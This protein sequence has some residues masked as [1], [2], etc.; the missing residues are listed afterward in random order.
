MLREGVL[1]V[2]LERAGRKKWTG[3]MVHPHGYLSPFNPQLTPVPAEAA[4]PACE[5]VIRGANKSL[6]WVPDPTSVTNLWYFF[7]PDVVLPDVLQQLEENPADLL[8]LDVAEWTKNPGS[9]SHTCVPSELAVKV[10]EWAAL[11]DEVMLAG[12]NEQLYG[13]MGIDTSEQGYGEGQVPIYVSAVLKKSRTDPPPSD[14]FSA[15][16]PWGQWRK[17]ERMGPGT[18]P[19]YVEVH[20]DRLKQI[21]RAL[22][23]ELSEPK[24]SVGVVAACH[25]AIGIA[26]ET[27]HWRNKPYRDLI[28]WGDVVENATGAPAVTGPEAPPSGNKQSRKTRFEI[29][30]GW[31]KLEALFKQRRIAYVSREIEVS[32]TATREPIFLEDKPAVLPGTARSNSRVFESRA[33]YA[34]YLKRIES[35]KTGAAKSANAR[36]DEYAS[37]IDLDA[38]EKV[39]TAYAKKSKEF[40]AIAN[41]RAP[42]SLA[43]VDCEQLRRALAFYDGKGRQ[44]ISQ[45]VKCAAQING[46]L[47][48]FNG[49]G[50]LC[51]K[52]LMTWAKDHSDE[53]KNLLWRGYLMNQE[54][55]QASFRTAMEAAQTPATSVA[56]M[57]QYFKDQL[58]KFAKFNDLMADENKTSIR[59][60]KAIPIFG[61][62][63]IINLIGHTIFKA[64]SGKLNWEKKLARSLMMSLIAG[65]GSPAAIELHARYRRVLSEVTPEKFKAIAD[66]QYKWS[67][68]SLKVESHAT[69]NKIMAEGGSGDFF[70]MRLTGVM[71]LVE[72]ILLSFKAKQLADAKDVD[73]AQKAAW[74]LGAAALT[75]TSAGLEIGA[76]TQEWLISKSFPHGGTRAMAEIRLGGF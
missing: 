74:E 35:A 54:D 61:F 41:A 71:T 26:Q 70:K 67:Q 48:G 4:A 68:Q 55:A 66:Y 12:L 7:H 63:P 3:Y 25:D 10:A 16:N 44:D 42:D 37:G 23:G 24:R 33:D 17:T 59:I 13:V 2:L 69:I 58:D 9:Q 57:V 62:S 14:I 18:L 43:W 28:Q 73:A 6:V 64:G 56:S 27:N 46:I 22:A 76:M 39:Q 1:Y 60:C 11:K 53:P 15:D 50:E 52:R 51:E 72:G 30:N 20:R 21:A 49:G 34:A 29:A 45:G 8:R 31:K 38:M 32:E 36:W 19:P 65:A 40:E 75:T 47:E 5:V